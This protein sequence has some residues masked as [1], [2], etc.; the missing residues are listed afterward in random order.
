MKYKLTQGNVI[1]RLDDNAC[2][3]IDPLNVDYQEY[4]MW[5]SKS[6]KNKPEP[7]DP[8]ITPETLTP[9]QKLQN[10]GLTVDELKSLLGL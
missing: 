10:A 2:I 7:A 3:P 5:L 6:K 1:I 8:I 4:L 9:E